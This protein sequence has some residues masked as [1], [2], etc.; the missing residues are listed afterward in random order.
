MVDLSY[1]TAIKNKHVTVTSRD[2]M[3]SITKDEELSKLANII[4]F[5]T[6]LGGRLPNTHAVEYYTQKKKSKKKN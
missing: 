6:A 1:D 4:G 5:S 2:L 3:F